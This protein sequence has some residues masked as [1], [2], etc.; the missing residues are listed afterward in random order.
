MALALD[1]KSSTNCP[2]RKN[3]PGTCCAS[4]V[5]RIDVTASFPLPASNVRAT[6]LRSVPRVVR[7]RPSNRDGIEQVVGAGVAGGFVGVLVD[8]GRVGWGV[9]TVGRAVVEG[10]GR[11][12]VGVGRVVAGPGGTAAGVE[13]EA[14]V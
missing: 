6:S 8:V 4:R 10:L 1:G 13:G 7:S 5:R 14:P 12:P 11:M 3:D 2:V 9:V